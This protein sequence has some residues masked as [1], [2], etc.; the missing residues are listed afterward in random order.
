MLEDLRSAPNL[1]TA[2]RFILVPIL[3]IFASL[4]FSEIVGVGILLGGL[5]DA[6][7][8]YLARRTGSVSEFGSKFDSIADQ[9]LQLSTIVWLFMLQPNIFSEN[10]MLSLIAL[11][12]YLLSL[13]VGIVKFKRIAN[14]HLYLSKIVGFFLY[15]FVVHAFIIG[16]YNKVLFLLAFVGFILSSSE[17][18][19]LQLISKS[20]DEHMGSLFFAYLVKDHP[21]RK[22][23]EKLP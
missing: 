13:V 7:D 9:F 5:S 14:L 8:G 11:A 6:F 17:T 23:V 15:I 18:F 19:I 1:L 2:F 21:I 22:I 4:G 10:S 16:R 20:V 12:T 3:W